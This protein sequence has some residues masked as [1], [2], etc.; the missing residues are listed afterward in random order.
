ML[1]R[2][3]LPATLSEPFLYGTASV[4]KASPEDSQRRSWLAGRRSGHAV[5]LDGRAAAGWSC[6]RADCS[7]RRRR[8]QGGK[9]WDGA[10]DGGGR[11]GRSRRSP[12]KLV[13]A[14]PPEELVTAPLMEELV[15]ALPEERAAGGARP[16]VPAEE[17]RR[18]SPRRA[19]ELARRRRDR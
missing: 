3:A 18:R 15:G 17:G 4:K 13:V 1:Q 10:G 12:E 16:H 9:G 8:G 2:S 6:C 5:E 7:I 11:A 19:A 14:A